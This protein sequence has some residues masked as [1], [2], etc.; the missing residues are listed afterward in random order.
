MLIGRTMAGDA[1]ISRADP[2]D[3]VFETY[4]SAIY[5]Y[6]LRLTGN[7][8]D[9]HDLSLTTFEK[10]FRAWGRQPADLN[11]R[12]WLYRIATNACLDEF[13]RR[14]LVTWIRWDPFGSKH[15]ATAPR[16]DP[17]EVA[18]RA[19]EGALLRA[20]L[21]QLSPRDRA[22]LVLRECEGL[23][24]EQI[25]ESLGIARPSVK[26]VLFRARQRLRGA[27]LQLAGEGNT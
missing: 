6:V 7:A 15:P 24:C 27:Y 22:A 12:P 25:G 13:R 23:T 11:V 10:A 9:A 5:A 19:E 16:D 26:V 18:I 21:R 2:F 17:E 20:A 1:S 8:D 4:Q 14:K 3:K